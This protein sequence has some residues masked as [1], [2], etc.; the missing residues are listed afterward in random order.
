MTMAHA[1]STPTEGVLQLGKIQLP[2]ASMTINTPSMML[3]ISMAW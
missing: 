3:P 2:L 1:S